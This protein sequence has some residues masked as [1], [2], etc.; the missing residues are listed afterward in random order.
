V[1]FP[2]RTFL[3]IAI[4]LLTALLP[5]LTIHERGMAIQTFSAGEIPSSSGDCDGDAVNATSTCDGDCTYLGV[6]VFTASPIRR[7]GIRQMPAQSTMPESQS[8]T[9]DPFPPRAA[10]VA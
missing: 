8:P 4:V 1:G 5:S 2:L 7:G 6:A 9:R 3:A 10:S